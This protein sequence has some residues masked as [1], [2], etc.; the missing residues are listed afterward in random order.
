MTTTGEKTIYKLTGLFAEPRAIVAGADGNLWF[1]GNNK[2]IKS[3]TAGKV[4][5]YSLPSGSTPTGIAVGADKTSGSPTTTATRSARS[6]H[7]ARSPN[8]RWRPKRDLKGSSP[9]LMATYGSLSVPPARS[10]RSRHLARLPPTHCQ[11]AVDHTRS[12][13]QGARCGSARLARAR[14]ARSLRPA[15]SPNSA[16]TTEAMF[17]SKSPPALTAGCG[18]VNRNRNRSTS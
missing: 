1:T 4:T 7:P 12:P 14:S 5:E 16:R 3:T 6:P 2:I 17:P 9:A 13:L 10:A 18:S 11:A 8:T 15:Q